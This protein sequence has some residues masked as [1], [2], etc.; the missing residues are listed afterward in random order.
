MWHQHSA[1][2]TQS[3]FSLDS[4]EP[5]SSKYESGRLFFL[6]PHSATSGEENKLTSPRVCTSRGLAGYRCVWSFI[7]DRELALSQCPAGHPLWHPAGAVHPVL[8]APLGSMCLYNVG[9]EQGTCLHGRIV[10]QD[11]C[12]PEDDAGTL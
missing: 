6:S 10:T 12:A 1:C 3:E 7:K 8:P 5:V 2:V 11:P 9:N 4:R